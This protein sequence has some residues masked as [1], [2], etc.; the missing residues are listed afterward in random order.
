MNGSRIVDKDIIKE[1][2]DALLSSNWTRKR[3]FKLDLFDHGLSYWMMITVFL[4]DG[5]NVVVQGNPS[6]DSEYIF[7]EYSLPDEVISKIKDLIENDSSLKHDNIRMLYLP[8]GI[9]DDDKEL[10]GNAWSMRA[11][12]NPYILATYPSNQIYKLYYGSAE[13]QL[14]TIDYQPYP[15]LSLDSAN[16]VM[17]LAGE[18][19]TVLK[20]NHV[21]LSKIEYH[22]REQICLF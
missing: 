6:D 5:I 13:I 11:T 8:D 9:P 22:Y 21:D 7:D 17:K 15:G 18:I 10:P 19:L 4:K 14:C 3:L 1:K 20:D 12:R 16:K 2:T